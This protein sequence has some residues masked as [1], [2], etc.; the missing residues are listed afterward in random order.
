[1]QAHIRGYGCEGW[2]IAGVFDILRKEL[3]IPI[4]KSES[5]PSRLRGHRAATEGYFHVS[6]QRRSAPP[7]PNAPA[8]GPTAQMSQPAKVTKLGF[9]RF[10]GQIQL[11]VH[12]GKPTRN[13]GSLGQV[14][15]VQGSA[16]KR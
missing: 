11:Q 13:D 5:S 12:R 10:K 16:E 14:R 3:S 2:R 1:M 9:H 4:P 15:W 7:I 6:F 8:P